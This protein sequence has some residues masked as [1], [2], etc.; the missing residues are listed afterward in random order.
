MSAPISLVVQ[1]IGK[2]RPGLIDHLSRVISEA[3]G[4]WESSRLIRLA[5]Q[6]AGMIHVVIR[7]DERASLER[8]IAA[9][10]SA[11][12]L[13]ISV[14][15]SPDSGASGSVPEAGPLQLEVVGQ[16]RPGIVSAISHEL[17]AMGA[18][19]LELATDCTNAPWSGERLFRAVA[20]V[21]PRAGMP[22]EDVRERIE[23][24]ASDLMVEVAFAEGTGEAENR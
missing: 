15:P 1:F 24:I 7:E 2:D 3:G 10:G 18:N 23:A 9:V 13:T 14:L 5:G 20:S 11:D 19:V 6:F 21:E 22:A 8:D 17:A 12:G 4:N 16:N